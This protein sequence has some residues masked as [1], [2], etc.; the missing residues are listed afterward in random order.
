MGK[1]IRD[2]DDTGVLI[3]DRDD[4]DATLTCDEEDDMGCCCCDVRRATRLDKK[5]NN[6][7]WTHSSETRTME[8]G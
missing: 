6:V 3:G 4:N 1:G 7:P 2:G 8:G 5:S